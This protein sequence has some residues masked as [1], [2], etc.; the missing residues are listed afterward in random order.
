MFL[1]LFLVDL[2]FLLRALG[3]NALS[4]SGD[5][6]DSPLFLSLQVAVSNVIRT[7]QSDEAVL[8][9]EWHHKPSCTPHSLE[10]CGSSGIPQGRGCSD[11]T[12]DSIAHGNTL[13]L[14]SLS[15]VK[16]RRSWVE[17]EKIQKLQV[18]MKTGLCYNRRMTSQ[19][20]RQSLWLKLFWILARSLNVLSLLTVCFSTVAHH[21]LIAQGPCS[22]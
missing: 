4:I 13:S 1:S 5:L 7:G 9:R 14:S 3:V 17:V 11:V 22:T 20:Y 2:S 21:Q 16:T 15:L 19:V 6:L 8:I 12:I 18:S 10:L